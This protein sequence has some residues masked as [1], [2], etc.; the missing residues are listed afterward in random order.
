MANVIKPHRGASTYMTTGAGKNVVLAEGELF[1]EL[2]DSGFSSGTAKIKIGDGTTAYSN[3]PFIYDSGGTVT[4]VKVGTTDYNPT[5]G[6]VSLPAYPTSLPASD[7]TNSYSATGTAPVTGTAVAAALGTLDVTGA[8]SISAG[9]TI[10]AWSETDGKVSITT[11]DISITKSQVSDFPTSLPASNTTDTYSATGTVPVS[12][13]AVAAALGTLDVTGDNSVA[14]SKT[15]SAW[16]ETDG[17]VSITTQ[18]IS[19]TKSQVSDFP[20][21]GT[22]AAKNFT[23]SVTQNS[24]DLVTSG[25]VWSAIDNLPEPMVFKGSL[26]T[27]GTITSLPTAAAA[28]TGY[29]YKVITAGTYGSQAAK[30]GD[31]FISDGS[32]WVYIPSAD[33]P[34]GT[35]TSV[36]ISNGGGI[37]VSG[38]P[39]TSSGTITI[40]HSDTSSQ[41]SVSNSG[42]T[43]IQS[44]T[45]DTYGHVTALSS[46]TETVTNTDRYVNSASFANDDT[47]SN[48]KMTLTRAG[49]DTAT[50]T[51]NIPKVSS[52]SAGVVPKGAAVSRQSQTT[53]FLREDGSWAA[54]SY[55]TNTD[56]KVTS[57]ANHYAP[58]EDTSAKLSADASST[59]AATWNSTSLVTGVD[60]KRDAKGHVVG[61]AVDSIKMPANP[62]T[63]TTYTF[64]NG[65]N[66]FTVT[67]SGGSAQTVTVTPSISNNVTGSGT[68]GY[69]AKFNG[70][71][72]ITNGPA[73]GSATTTYLR[74][75]GTW[76][77]PVDSTKVAK[78]GDTMTGALN[79]A[80][81]IANTVGD[82]VKIG[83]C[84]KSGCL[85]VQGA[86]GTTGIMLIKQGAT[87]GATSESASIVYNHT[88]KCIDFVFI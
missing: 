39:I 18:N 10:S 27:G 25:A 74:N 1:V 63:N 29:V 51:A 88:N 23:T 81:G 19:I 70:A 73:F 85:G 16:S 38:S 52:S 72:T 13:K 76:Q 43:Y 45:L 80:N 62:N 7:K 2:P 84:N 5:D 48:V 31:L 66:G 14:A 58:A 50:V 65:T 24:A 67:P 32:S 41:A 47:N 33:E 54:P 87:W 34:N 36:G 55:T 44:I 8:S 79:F 82:D 69:I 35:V 20:S 83:D 28:N 9:K 78:S 11:Q 42:R 22:A 40:S 21:L 17:K 77:T 12:G 56:T 6:I 68:S 4:K 30:I 61:V 71:N 59:T 26:G 64:A 75:D 86:N 15:I 46:G 53:K 3:L 37:S 57:A 60:I 49:S